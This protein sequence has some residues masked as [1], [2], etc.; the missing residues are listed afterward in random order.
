MEEH[1]IFVVLLLGVLAAI[2]ATPLIYHEA[3]GEP[4]QVPEQ[5]S[6]G[7]YIIGVDNEYNEAYR[8]NETRISQ[9]TRHMDETTATQTTAISW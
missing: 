6:W 5:S 8:Y 4:V 9:Y 7:D 3:T 1:L 2:A